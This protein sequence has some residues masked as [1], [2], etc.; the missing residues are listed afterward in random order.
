MGQQNIKKRRMESHFWFQ[1][2]DY[3]EEKTFHI[4]NSNLQTT[5]GWSD[6]AFGPG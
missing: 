6:G 4:S 2:I 5:G 3:L 1:R